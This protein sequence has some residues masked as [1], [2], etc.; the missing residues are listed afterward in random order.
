MSGWNVTP[1]E[2]PMGHKKMDLRK[3]ADLIDKADVTADPL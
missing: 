1:A 3:L 2:E